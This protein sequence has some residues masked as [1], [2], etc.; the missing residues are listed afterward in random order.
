MGVELFPPHLDCLSEDLPAAP[1]SRGYTEWSDYSGEGFDNGG[2][3][4]DIPV[5]TIHEEIRTIA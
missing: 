2:T 4:A 5:L 1:P 3:Q